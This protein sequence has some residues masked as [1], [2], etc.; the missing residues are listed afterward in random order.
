MKATLQPTPPWLRR[1]NVIGLGALSSL[2]F[3]PGA[4]RVWAQPL[5]PGVNAPLSHG[6]LVVVFLRGAYDGLSALVPYA[7]R[8]YYA[9]RP[10]IAIAAP[11]GS[12]QTASGWTTPLRCTRP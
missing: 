3:F 9:S 4:R 5:P 12:A 8:D 2:A 7:D 10:N 11:D 6:R 1:R